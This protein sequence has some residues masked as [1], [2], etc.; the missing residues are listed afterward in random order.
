[1][2]PN[3]TA[4]SRTE[5]SPRDFDNDL[6]VS[7]AHIDDQ[8]LSE[9]QKGWISSF[10][11]ALEI[12]L[13]QLLGKQPRIW[14]DPKLAGNDYFADKLEERLPR[15]AALVSVIS[16]RYVRSDWC[17][18]ELE[19]FCKA[20]EQTGGL[21]VADKARVFK[22]VKTPVPL[23]QH[24]AELQ[25]LLGY[26]FFT[27]EP[28]TGRQRELNDLAGPEAQR[29]YWARLDDL[30]HD[31][32]ELLGLL[33]SDRAARTESGPA[34]SVKGTV[35]LAETS[36]DLK[37]KRDALKRDLLER[38]YAVLP[39]RPL[40]LYGPDCAA[41]V[42]EQIARCKL[43]IHLVG[44]SY[45]IV[46]EGST[47]SMVELQHE[48]AVERSAG[49]G[50]SR[51]VWLPG[52]AAI[53]E[54]TERDERQ[55]RF[56]AHLRTDT[57]SQECADLLESTLEDFKTALHKRLEAPVQTGG[58]GA[59]PAGDDGPP[60]IYL[61]CDQRDLETITPLED[62]LFDQ[63]YEVIL[64]AFAGDEGQVRRDHEESLG[65][66]D[67]ALLYY[68]AGGELWLRQKL[69]EVQKAA[70]Y[71]RSGPIATRAIYVGPPESAQKSRFR[72]HEAL[73]LPPQAGDFTPAALGPFLKLLAT[74]PGV[75][76]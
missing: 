42:R 43:S 57:R 12:R 24:P 47:A 46:P 19:E 2:S 38:G 4:T 45:G 3:R 55:Q 5:T 53:D 48:L 58:Q 67:A 16:P 52:T 13:G 8:A 20:S 72:T 65:I 39:D 44:Q 56:I 40:P 11:R 1:M 21:R 60:R 15:S 7:Y 29:K 50:F 27:V 14:R 62:H 69:R 70:A 49:A 6:F 33:D 41:M 23:E 32:S 66:C 17:R 35:Y 34:A 74:N 31:I 25:E 76:A 28:D 54:R 73:V 9:G 37:E 26:D 71:G 64:P 63:G 59:R 30:A 68:G 75:R 10:H 36:F 22:V 51:L 61:I 18:R